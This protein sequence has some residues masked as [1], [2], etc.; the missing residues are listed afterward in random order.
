MQR[1]YKVYKDCLTRQLKETVWLQDRQ[2]TLNSKGE[3]GGGRIP[4]MVIEKNEYESKKEQIE[5]F[6]RCEE[7]KLKW[8]KIKE[9]FEN[10]E[11]ERGIGN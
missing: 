9:E 5:R 4:R 1:I 2:G 3:F 11:G 7:M 8:K 10:R 6:R